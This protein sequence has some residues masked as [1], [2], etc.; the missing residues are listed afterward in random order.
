MMKMNMIRLSSI[1]LLVGLSATFSSCSEDEESTQDENVESITAEEAAEEIATSISTDVVNVTEDADELTKDAEGD[2]GEEFST[3]VDKDLETLY[4]SYDLSIDYGYTLACTD[5]DSSSLTYDYTSEYAVDAV[6][7][8]TAGSS[9]GSLTASGLEGDS[10]VYSVS[11]ELEST[12]N[13]IGKGNNARNFDSNLI[14]TLE[15]I[16]VDKET[17]VIQSGT[18][19]YLVIA[20]SSTGSEVLY[21]ASLTFNGDGTVTIIIKG[22]VFIAN[23]ENGELI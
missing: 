9:T 17:L 16:V 7:F 15:D 10:T 19:E 20:T 14:G 23:C 3:Q 4:S 18:A 5:G 6:R 21:N 1:I 13:V 22:E 12:H 11:G 2:C 8:A